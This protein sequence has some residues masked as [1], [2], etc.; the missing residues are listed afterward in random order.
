ML[1]VVMLPVVM[2]PVVMLPV[3]MLPVVMQTVGK[4][5]VGKLAALMSRRTTSTDR[6]PEATALEAG[7]PATGWRLST[8]SSPIRG[9]GPR[10]ATLVRR[11]ADS[12]GRRSVIRRSGQT[13]RS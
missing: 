7:S 12:Q 9:R 6:W 11:T 3:V 2:L 1:P 10:M 8:S 5:T 13:R 4:Q